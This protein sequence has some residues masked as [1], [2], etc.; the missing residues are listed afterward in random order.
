[1]SVVG[2]VRWTVWCL[3]CWRVWVILVVVLVV[4]EGSK[5]GGSSCGDSRKCHSDRQQG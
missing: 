1:M 2:V 3:S 5:V 4:V